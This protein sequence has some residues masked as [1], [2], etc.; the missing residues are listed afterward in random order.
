MKHLCVTAVESYVSHASLGQKNIFCLKKQDLSHLNR[1]ELTLNC[2][3]ASGV[4]REYVS[5]GGN[6]VNYG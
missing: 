3:V 6:V 1:Q 2:P 5:V 4:A